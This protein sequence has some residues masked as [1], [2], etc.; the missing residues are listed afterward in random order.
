MNG[1]YDGAAPSSINPN[2]PL[3]A[4]IPAACGETF[5]DDVNRRYK[6]L[7]MALSRVPHDPFSDGTS[8]V[9]GNI[10]LKLKGNRL[11]VKMTVTGAAPNLPHAQHL[12]GFLAPGTTGVCPTEIFRNA[13]T[14]DGL[15]SVMEGSTSYGPIL[16]AL[17]TSGDASPSSALAVDRFPVASADGSYTY[18]RVFRVSDMIAQRLEDLLVIIHGR[19]SGS[20]AVTLHFL[21]PS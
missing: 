1:A 18:R 13:I 10:N 3:E 12:H 11:R 20:G 14:D 19:G 6:T 15:I 8:N 5:F 7:D 4:T 2:L 9:G 21:F 17:T 16:L